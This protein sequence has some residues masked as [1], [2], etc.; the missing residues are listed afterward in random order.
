MIRR[1]G[2]T[3]PRKLR[4][5]ALSALSA[6]SAILFFAAGAATA[7]IGDLDLQA[8]VFTT[9]QQGDPTVVIRPDNRIVVGWRSD[10]QDG[11]FGGIYLRAFDEDGAA[12]TGEIL[13][14]VTTNGDQ[15]RPYIAL[16][17]TG[18]LVAIWQF[19]A[20]GNNFGRVF[21]KDLIPTTDEFII[22]QMVP[23]KALERTPT[24]AVFEDGDFIV[25]WGG[26]STEVQRMNADGTKLGK[27]IFP[28]LDNNFDTLEAVGG[29]AFVNDDKDFLVV[30]HA[31]GVDSGDVDA[32]YL[33]PFDWDG[34][35]LATGKRISVEDERDES[36]PYIT[37]NASGHFL[38]VWQSRRPDNDFDVIGRLFT[39]FDDPVGEPFVANHLPRDGN[40]RP[41]AKLFDD[42]QFIVI[43][44]GI[45]EGGHSDEDD[46]YLRRF[47]K[48]GNPTTGDIIVNHFQNG[49]QDSP[50]VSANEDGQF[51]VVWLSTGDQDGDESG[52]FFQFDNIAT[53]PPGDDDL[54]D[55][56]D[57]DDTEDEDDDEDDDTDDVDDD[58]PSIPPG[59]DDEDD[60]ETITSS[61]GLSQDEDDDFCC[62]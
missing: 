26:T 37:A 9:G 14:N 20:F 42:G 25:A 4:L 38:I 61:D 7:D 56:D 57:D 48:N 55:D 13:A 5:V 30:G 17:G 12:Q 41:V 34:N 59:E 18:N 49:R 10:N 27:S 60:P 21:D 35:A 15:K 32:V 51:A 52:I 22:S 23:V 6:L 28:N 62:G 29:S 3:Q 16:D 2:P 36:L 43:W 45:R 54:T 11:S 47:D 50:A 24:L 39:S 8:N 58:A 31:G 46:I 40:T 1:I 33:R 19:E 53:L 44:A